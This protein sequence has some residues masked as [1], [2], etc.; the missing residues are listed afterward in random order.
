MSAPMGNKN[1]EKYT[2]EI[3][4][5]LFSDCL[6]IALDTTLDCNDF[7]GEVA[8]K[9]GTN[10]KLLLQLTDKFPNLKDSF[11]AIKSACESN[12]FRNGKKGK[13]VPSL[14]IMNLKSNHGWKDRTDLTTNDKPINGFLNIDPLA[15]DP[16][17]ASTSEAV[18]A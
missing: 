8:Q 15:D 5:K 2:L 10:H 3:A 12:C 14:A 7:I 4:E 13:I 18:K 9:C 16:T 17:D 6:E 1:A 11:E